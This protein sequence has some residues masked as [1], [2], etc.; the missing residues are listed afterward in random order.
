MLVRHSTTTIGLSGVL[1]VT[2]LFAQD[3]GTTH[4]QKLKQIRAKIHQTEEKREAAE[5][6]EASELYRLQNLDLDI[7]IAHSVVLNLQKEQ[8]KR[9][10]QINSLKKDIAR[11]Q[12][13]LEQLRELFKKRIIHIYKY[14]RMKD[15]EL[16]LTTRSVNDGLLW[17]E[18]QK[19]LSEQD[20]RSFQRIRDKQTKIT[21]DRDL[22]T[23]ELD[24]E[25]NTLK[26]KRAEENGLKK[27]YQARERSLVAIR[28][29][30]KV[31][32]Q[33]LQ[34]WHKA[35]KEIENLIT[36]LEESAAGQPEMPPPD[37]TF[38]E[39]KGR[40]IWP[41]EGRI[42]TKFGRYRHPQL[43]TVTESI[44]IEISAP[45]GTPVVAVA[46][47]KITAITWQRGRGN[48]VIAR[49]YGGYY[50][51]YTHLQEIL[52][53][54]GDNVYMGEKLG[55]VGESGSLKGPLLHFEIWQGAQKKVNP[56]IWL[57]KQA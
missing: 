10:R 50:T 29:D 41:A 30:I 19:R 23:I 22:L 33:Q 15:V 20:Y 54:I 53:N 51:V 43:K 46:S 3:P 9:Q 1:A 18:Y 2:L 35:E 5:K 16:L 24:N 56:E 34:D 38:A 11:N 40:M 12:K 36:R 14:G 26:R 45:I 44:G 48:I 49:H 31:Y 6:K 39:L 37:I 21:Y 52:V 4:Q 42:V 47:G 32:E 7:D 28:K 8:K 57:A 25:R 13:E 17:L 55:T 27:K